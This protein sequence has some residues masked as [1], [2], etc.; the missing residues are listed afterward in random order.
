MKPLNEKQRL[1]YRRSFESRTLARSYV[2]LNFGAVDWET[3][4]FVN[5]KEV[6]DQGGYDGFS[7]DITDALKPSGEQELVVAVFDPTDA[8][9]QPR[10]KQIRNPTRDLV[11]THQRHLADGLGR[12]RG[13]SAC[14][15]FKLRRTWTTAK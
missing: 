14:R 15:N 10:G 4:V 9:T 6:G 7:F 11:H 2:L 5:G 12:A 3:T 1:W 13:E 8:G